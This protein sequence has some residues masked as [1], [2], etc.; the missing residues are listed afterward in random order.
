M[1]TLESNDTEVQYLFSAGRNPIS[2]GDGGLAFGSPKCLHNRFRW[3]VVVRSDKRIS[4][5]DP[6]SRVKI[7]ESTKER[8]FRSSCPWQVGAQPRCVDE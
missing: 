5:C 3:S 8:A 7:T 1:Q 2:T 4:G 6:D